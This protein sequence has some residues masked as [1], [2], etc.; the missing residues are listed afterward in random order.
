MSGGGDVGWYSGEKAHSPIQ[1]VSGLLWSSKS[2]SSPTVLWG[3]LGFRVSI[4]T[5]KK[6]GNRVHG[7]IG[8]G[9]SNVDDKFSVPVCG[10]LRPKMDRVLANCILSVK[11]GGLGLTISDDSG[12]VG[13]GVPILMGSCEDRAIVI[14][15]GIGVGC[16][17][18]N[19]GEVAG[20]LGLGDI[21]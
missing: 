16:G 10:D 8:V 12:V 18:K 9:D 1:L 5:F 7:G 6:G 11:E 17:G 21:G 4:R 13:D 2:I 19:I 14:H 20:R 15:L 3:E